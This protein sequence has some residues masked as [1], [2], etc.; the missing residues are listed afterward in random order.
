[1]GRL[2]NISHFS[3]QKYVEEVAEDAAELRRARADGDESLISKLQGEASR[4]M[5]L[6]FDGRLIC[7]TSTSLDFEGNPLLSLPKCTTVLFPLYLQDWEREIVDEKISD[8][9][10]DAYVPVSLSQA[11]SDAVLCRIAMAQLSGFQTESCY[12]NER[13]TCTFPRL[14]SKDPVPRVT[15]MRAWEKLGSPTK[16]TATAR[17]VA[18]L[19]S[20]DDVPI[21]LP[22]DGNITV[23]DRTPDPSSTR[24]VL[25]YQEFTVFAQLLIDVSFY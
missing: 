10:I 1:M 21:P 5:Q 13:L 12:S 22:V 17:L 18:Y 4:R 24:K 15:S 16:I 19:L 20:G 6:Q 14:N 9:S 7:R 11:H 25:V 2:C 3:C 23:P 8:E